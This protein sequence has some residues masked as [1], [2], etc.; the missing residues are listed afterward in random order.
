M[1]STERD[2]SGIVAATRPLEPC[3]P[4]PPPR[5]ARGALSI[6]RDS[7]EREPLTQL[8]GEAYPLVERVCASLRVP[9][10]LVLG[11]SRWRPLVRAR[12]ALWAAVREELGWSFPAIGRCFG[13]DH[14]TVLL[15]I[16]THF[17]REGNPEHAAAHERRRL[18]SRLRNALVEDVV[19]ARVVGEVAGLGDQPRADVGALRARAQRS[20]AA[21]GKESNPTLGQA[22]R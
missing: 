9:V 22:Q 10:V 17:A 2:P 7:L 16:R 3:S 15:G 18:Q 1:N 13:V 14:T 5:R 21:H 8:R 20:V 11:R 6:F 12:H 4:W 19:G